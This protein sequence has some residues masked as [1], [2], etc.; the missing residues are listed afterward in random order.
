MQ[1]TPLP[2]HEQQPKD[3]YCPVCNHF[4]GALSRCP[5]CGAYVRKRVSLRVVRWGAILLGT[6]GLFLLYLMSIHKDIPIV[7]IG[8]IEPTMNF[9]YV[10]IAGTVVGDTRVYRTGTA[11]TGLRFHIDDGTGEIPVNAYKKQAI[12]M[13]EQDQ[14]PRM[15]DHVDVAGSLSVS[16]DDQIRLRM[17]AMDQLH[18]D[19]MAVPSVSL[20]ELRRRSDPSPVS[21]E[22]V[23]DKI[24]VPPPGSGKPWKLRI[25]DGTASMDVSFW[26]DVYQDIPNKEKL[27]PGMAIRARVQ[28]DEYRGRTQL[29]LGTGRDLE[30]LKEAPADIGTILKKEE[31]EAEG[32]VKNFY[33]A[34]RD[35]VP[36]LLILQSGDEETVVV[37]WNDIRSQLDIDIFEKGMRLQ[38]KGILDEYKGKKRIKIITPDGIRQLD[39]ETTNP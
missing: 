4:V 23:I 38:V 5:H 17:Q 37:F 8:E 9:A 33:R 3:I 39:A 15:G 29:K 27:G 28:P 13:V 20:R 18:I 31:L 25:S 36:N 10:R 35:A 16:A 6:L 14:L 7:K 1:Q 12:A 22:A 11:I 30:F 19:S 24:N 32:V 21:V 2:G 34:K 26:D